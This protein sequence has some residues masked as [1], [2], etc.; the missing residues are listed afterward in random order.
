[1][2]ISWPRFWVDHA[3]GFNYI[4]PWQERRNL[5]LSSVEAAGFGW[6]IVLVAGIGFMTD[7]YDIFSINTIIPM[8]SIVYW[9]GNFPTRYALGVNI[10]TLVGSMIGQIVFGFLADR[11]GRR[12]VYG[13]ELLV[14]IAASFGF[15]TASTGAYN[16]MSLI[17]LLIF[18]RLVMGIGIG[19]DYPLSAVITAEFAP[20]KY[21]ARMLAAVFFFQPLGQ[22]IAVLMAFAAT[23]GFRSYIS[24][25]TE[26]SCSVQAIDLPGIPPQP[27]DP[28]CVRTIDR[29]WRLVAGLGAV[30]ALVAMVFRLT[31]P[32]SVYYILDI[33]NDSNEAMHAKEYFGSSDD[34]GLNDQVSVDNE[35]IEHTHKPTANG[36]HVTTELQLPQPALASTLNEQQSVEVSAPNSIG[37]IVE[38]LED[39]HPS[40][41]SRADLYQYLFTED[42]WTD[43]FATSINWMFLDFTFYLLGVNTSSFV[44]VL[45][46]QE[47][48]NPLPLKAPSAPYKWLIETERDIMESTSIGALIGSI[49]AIFAM[50]FLSRKRIQMWGFLILGGLFIIV[51]ALYVTLPHTKAH[52]A[53]VVFYG[54]CQLF[55]N[56]GPNTTTFIIPAE[57]FPTRYRCTLY[58]IAAASG[59]LGSVLGQVVVIKVQNQTR[60]GITLILF[61]IVMLVGAAL[62]R[63][64]TP[65]TCDIH[66]KSRKLED[67][68]KGK[69]H[70]REMEREER[71][72]EESRRKQQ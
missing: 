22:L 37:P 60:L 48:G 20:T 3:Q 19:A 58:G 67:L 23:A 29:A 54:I 40:Q 18:W 66:G 15:A 65:E 59:K 61:V 51:G 10:A 64:L 42:N 52:V 57:A 1:M 70:R 24:T 41:A 6:W 33:K 43:L 30:P 8:L 17:A 63:Y 16:S 14:T 62:T 25:A 50:H 26:R 53:I 36:D 44:S 7:A 11:Y 34:L 21:R 9:K 31:I 68:A 56:L 35:E 27:P 69:L 39:P 28:T 12:K 72:A 5:V 47:H 49:M 71:D 46:G 45:Y 38:E 4:I 13:M 2:P 55:Y 32:E